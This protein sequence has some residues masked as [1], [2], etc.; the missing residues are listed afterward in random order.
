MGLFG[1]GTYD[2][3]KLTAQTNKD[4]AYNQNLWNKE[5]EEN[6][7]KFN[8]NMWTL[9][10]EYNSP[11]AQ[12]QRMA[13]AGINPNFSN[14]SISTGTSS[15]PVQ[16]EAAQ[17][18]APPYSD[19]YL[20]SSIADQKTNLDSMLGVMNLLQGLPSM[21]LAQAQ[22]KKTEVDTSIA[23]RHQSN[24]DR[25][26]DKEIATMEANI[27][28]NGR[29]IELTEEQKNY[30]IK[31]QDLLGGQLQ[32]IRSR[33]NQINTEAHAKAEET[34]RAN[35]LQGYQT[36]ALIS[37]SNNNNASA[38][39]QRMLGN[40]HRIQGKTE[41]LI[42]NAVLE[43]N[44][45]DTAVKYANVNKTTQEFKNLI[46]QGKIA[47]ID[48]KYHDNLVKVSLGVENGRLR[49]YNASAKNQ[50]IKNEFET[51]NQ[52]LNSIG[53]TIGVIND[54]ISTIGNGVATFGTGGLNTVV[55]GSQKGF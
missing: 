52:W 37:Q 13:E 53:N 1:K 9:N 15:S 27:E 48:L 28:L 5:S 49:M 11:S 44:I 34:R 24:E 50:E 25:K 30:V 33:I 47:Q 39:A 17:S 23:Q 42:R 46:T 6:A 8:F 43:N 22:A 4:I 12:R 7:R 31:Q 2:A 18:V 55:N 35:E 32:E 20:Q 40:L 26:T 51:Y 16:G 36:D 19:A 45:A 29:Q 41:G 38:Y 14:G 54:G 21:Q 10:N 3:A